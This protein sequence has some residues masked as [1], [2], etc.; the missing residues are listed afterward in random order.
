VTGQR[1]CIRK[2][3]DTWTALWDIGP[4]ALS[5]KR[6]QR[7]KGGFATKKDAQAFLT[8]QIN[9]L[10][11]GTYVEP[12][13]QKLGEYLLT[14]LEGVRVGPKTMA[15]Y[16]M[17]VETRIIPKIGDLPIQRL[18]PTSLDAFYRWL[19]KNGGKSGRASVREASEWLTRFCTRLLA[20]GSGKVNFFAI[21][22]IRPPLQ[23]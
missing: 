14:W 7:S 6:R 21:Q 22:P 17:N 8:T 11:R 16:R 10:N 18:T 3:G 19:E 15:D 12:S 1:G 2:R 9:E 23:S 4:D 5:G 13:K 20:T